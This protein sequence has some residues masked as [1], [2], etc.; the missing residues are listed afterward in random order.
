LV[1]LFPKFKTI[2]LSN[3]SI[4]S[5]SDKDYSKNAACALKVEGVEKISI[6]SQK[7]TPTVV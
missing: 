5:A 7:N 6:L 3:L 4:L 1:L 2:L